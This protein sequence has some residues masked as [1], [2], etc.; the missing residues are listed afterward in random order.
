[1][2]Q[3]IIFVL[4]SVFVVFGLEKVISDKTLLLLLGGI[5]MGLLLF[6][7]INVREKKSINGEE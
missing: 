2:N 3:L 4:L 1:M 7:A 6:I 5:N